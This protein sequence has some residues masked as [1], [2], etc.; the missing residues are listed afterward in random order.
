MTATEKAWDEVENGGEFQK[1]GKEKIG[2]LF[3]Y[4]FLF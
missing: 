3:I 4:L 1:F 2:E